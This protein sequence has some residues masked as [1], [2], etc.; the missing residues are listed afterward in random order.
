MEIN[1]AVV[2]EK[3]GNFLIEDL[4]LENPREGEILVNVVA[5][6]VCHTD[7][8]IR[9]Q[10][11]PTPMPVVLG[12]EGAGIVEAVGPGVTTVNVGDQVLMSFASCGQCSSCL[13]GSPSYCWHHMEMNFSGSRYSGKDWSIPA[14][15]TKYYLD[16][17]GRKKSEAIN[18]A[19]FNQSAFATHA[20]ATENNV[21][22]VHPEV[23][24]TMV[25]PLGCG[26]QTGAGSIFNTLKPEIGSSLVVAGAGNVGLSAVMAAKLVGCDPII[27]IDVAKDRL[28]LALDLGATHIVDAS[29]TENLVDEITRISPGGVAYSIETTAN[30]ILFRSVVDMLQVRG[31]CGLIGGAKLGTEVAFD[32]SHL[33]FGR[34]VRGILQGDSKPKKFLPQL[35]ELFRSGKFPIDRL[36]THYS[37]SDIGKA[38]G[39]ME[40]GKTIKPVLVMSS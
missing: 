14:P 1:A 4:D 40:S 38:I 28:E 39:D 5:C 37:F 7:L 23:D 26:F 10:F 9:D 20:I 3:G 35:V 13:D 31:V 21:V 34:T 16:E 15:L 25:A 33:L 36:I 29:K 12:H 11:Y 6:G 8:I 17:N 22:V 2:R 24:L 32:M 30:P 19:F 18:G 27:V